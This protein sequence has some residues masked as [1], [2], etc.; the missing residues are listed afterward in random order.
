MVDS[1]NSHASGKRSAISTNSSCWTRLLVL[2][3][4]G[5]IHRPTI[6]LP[7]PL[8]MKMAK[9]FVLQ[10]PPEGLLLLAVLRKGGLAGRPGS[11]SGATRCP[12]KIVLW[13]A[14]AVKPRLSS[15]LP[16]HEFQQ[17]SERKYCESKCYLFKC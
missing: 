11:H 5:Q 8:A 15:H 17:L 3:V 10:I 6:L 13:G 2:G 7:L 14:A 4:G 12:L 16:P 1:S 9:N